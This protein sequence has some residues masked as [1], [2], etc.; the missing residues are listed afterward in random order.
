MGGG[1]VRRGHAITSR[2]RGRL[3]NNQPYERPERGG[4][5]AMAQR[6]ERPCNSDTTTEQAGD[7]TTNHGRER[8]WRMAVAES[9][10][11]GRQH[12]N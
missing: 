12:N 7:A 9:Q 4:M 3:C 11:H 10:V 2:T 5:G 1:G 6:E 8:Q